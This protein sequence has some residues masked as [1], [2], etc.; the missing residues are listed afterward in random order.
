MGQRISVERC[1]ANFGVKSVCD[2]NETWSGE[3]EKG[4]VP[5]EP[6]IAGV[7]VVYSFIAVTGFAALM[8]VCMLSWNGF[9][10]LK[11][12]HDKRHVKDVLHGTSIL[13]LDLAAI[14]DKLITACSD[15]QIVVGSAYLWG[16]HSGSGCTTSFYHLIVVSNM[17][18]LSCA[19][20]LLCIVASRHY[21]RN[22][23]IATVRLVLIFVIFGYAGKL[24]S[25]GYSEGATKVPADN[26]PEDGEGAAIF[27]LP[28]PCFMKRS[29]NLMLKAQWPEELELPEW[30]EDD[31][32]SRYMGWEMY[33]MVVSFTA[34]AVFITWMKE[35]FR[36]PPLDCKKGPRGLRKIVHSR[37]D[38]R[39]F[40]AK[41]ARWFTIADWVYRVLGVLVAT[42]AIVAAAHAVNFFRSWAHRTGWLE[43][44]DGDTQ[45]EESDIND[46]GQLLAA[47][48]CAL[49]FFVLIEESF[50]E[51]NSWR[52]RRGASSLSQD[53]GAQDSK[54][55]RTDTFEMRESRTRDSVEVS[56]RSSSEIEAQRI[57]SRPGGTAD[58]EAQPLQSSPR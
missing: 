12:R 29:N 36:P 23:L 54:G 31:I 3:H 33:L 55:D 9:V 17:I 48:S 7:G 34:F 30:K 35:L 1:Y 14:C 10:A 2:Y 25:G 42:G 38:I 43:V 22:P 50:T 21:Y 19:T 15:Q 8:S 51:F 26:M 5:T 49:I 40:M 27:F 58:Q 52:I 56:S 41:H 53:V 16:V 39:G 11:A 18:V 28:S 32:S 13:G 57:T 37:H 44:E 20:H 47:F 46:L 24:M 45:S 4:H 6:D